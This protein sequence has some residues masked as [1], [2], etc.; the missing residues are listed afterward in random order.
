MKKQTL[1]KDTRP[2]ESVAV[3]EK[4]EG[5]VHDAEEIKQMIYE[6]AKKIMEDSRLIKLATHR[7]KETDLHLWK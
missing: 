4:G 7:P 2:W 6:S 1:R 3:F 5:A